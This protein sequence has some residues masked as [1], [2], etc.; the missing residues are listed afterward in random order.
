MRLRSLLMSMSN[1]EWER[2]CRRSYRRNMMRYWIKRV[3][4]INWR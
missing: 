1:K 2:H 3:F 4:K